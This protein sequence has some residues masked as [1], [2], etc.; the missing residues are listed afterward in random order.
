MPGSWS[1]DSLRPE[2]LWL[3]GNWTHFNIEETTISELPMMRSQY[4]AH[5]SDAK[6]AQGFRRSSNVVKGL[7]ILTGRA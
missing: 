1:K 3:K 5:T 4:V 2:R 7:G 6:F